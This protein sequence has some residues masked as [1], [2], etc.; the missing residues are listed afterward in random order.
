MHR[1]HPCFYKKATS[2]DVLNRITISHD[3]EVIQRS[4]PEIAS[5]KQPLETSQEVTSGW[6]FWSNPI[7]PPPQVP[8]LSLICLPIVGRYCVLTMS[9]FQ[10]FPEVPSQHTTAEL[11]A[12]QRSIQAAHPQ[13]TPQKGKVRARVKINQ[14]KCLENISNKTLNENFLN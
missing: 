6:C 1:H 12:G 3:T 13:G 11:R 9:W 4:W 7:D 8:L 10:S 2:P 14:H 5:K